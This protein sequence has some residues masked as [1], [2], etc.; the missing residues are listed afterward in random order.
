METDRHQ[1]DIIQTTDKQQTH[2][3]QATSRQET[4]RRQADKRGVEID[5]QHR[6]RI[7]LASGSKQAARAARATPTAPSAC[8]VPQS[9]YQDFTQQ[10]P[11]IVAPKTASKRTPRSFQSRNLTE[12]SVFC[13]VLPHFRYR[14]VEFNSKSYRGVS[15]GLSIK[16]Q[17]NRL[18]TLI[19]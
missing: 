11:F 10:R 12:M 5:R 17:N 15:P 9:A 4:D 18:F 3:W 2:N 6:W 16:L 7:R 19:R 14:S 13:S 8:F 1:T